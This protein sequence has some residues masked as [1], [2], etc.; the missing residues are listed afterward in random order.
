MAHHN[1]HPPPPEEEKKDGSAGFGLPFSL[2]PSDGMFT[3]LL[4]R[5]TLRSIPYQPP[6]SE[7]SRQEAKADAESKEHTEV[8]LA[9]EFQFQNP[10]YSAMS[11]AVA[12]SVAG[13]LI[14][15][16][17]GRVRSVLDAPDCV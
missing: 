7:G 17:E 8:N 1:H 3:H 15:A 6:P 2:G 16:F 4:S 13:V 11:S 9:I 12:D 14:N 10:V 5:W